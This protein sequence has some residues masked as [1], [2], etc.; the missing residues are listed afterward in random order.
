VDLSTFAFLAYPVKA[1]LVGGL[2]TLPMLFAGIIFID[3]F[4]KVTRRDRALGANL[5][6]SLVGGILQ[7]LT[8]V[9]GI[10]GLLLIVAGLYFLAW[11]AR[12]VTVP[13]TVSLDED[14]LD[15]NLLNDLPANQKAT[16]ELVEGETVAV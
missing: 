10:K 13:R 7:S 4:A 12:P 11:L 5:I 2:T 6:G 9:L 3:S 15:K 16:A 8:F 1:I 14:E